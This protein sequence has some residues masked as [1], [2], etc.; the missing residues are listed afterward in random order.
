MKK[1]IVYGTLKKGG[2]LHGYMRDSKFIVDV[3]VTG[4]KM[5]DTKSG[6]PFIVRGDDE[7]DRIWGEKYEVDDETLRILDMVEGTGSGL[8]RRVDL[9]DVKSWSDKKDST[10][11]YVGDTSLEYGKKIY[12]VEPEEI[13][14]GFWKTN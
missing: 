6:F 1:V 14:D 8:F 4:Y 10:Y 11:I 7:I 5:Y 13:K 2:R 12:G 3:V 9:K